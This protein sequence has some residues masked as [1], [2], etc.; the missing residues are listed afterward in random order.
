MKLN[1]V[2]V[3][4]A[5]FRGIDAGF[6]GAAPGGVDAFSALF[7]HVYYVVGGP[8]IF[9]CIIAGKQTLDEKKAIFAIGINFGSIQHNPSPG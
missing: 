4:D 3:H 5:G 6:P 7:E 2:A 9:F 1:I 8:A